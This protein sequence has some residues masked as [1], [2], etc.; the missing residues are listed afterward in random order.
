MPAKSR[1]F[2]G[3]SILTG[4][5]EPAW[6]EGIML[7]CAHHLPRLLLCA[8]CTAMAL[9][10]LCTGAAMLQGQAGVNPLEHLIRSSGSWALRLLLLALAIAPARHAGVRLARSRAWRR[11]KRMSDWNWLIRLRRPVGLGAFFYAAAHLGLYAALD[12]DFSLEE[13]ASDLRHKPFIATGMLSFLLLAPLAVTSTDGWMKRLQRNWKRLHW[14]VFPAAILAESHFFLLSKTGVTGWRIYALALVALL[15][16][17]VLRGRVPT[18]PT[19]DRIDGTVAER[20]PQAA[21]SD[22]RQ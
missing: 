13:L 17:R 10:A 1:I 5:S 15:V 18:L 20:P 19:Q 12:L 11:G 3:G 22:I 6:V 2:T 9:P 16:Y 8:A 4:T 21:A 7:V 14:L